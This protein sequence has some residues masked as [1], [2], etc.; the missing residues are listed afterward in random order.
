MRVRNNK[1]LDNNNC[2]LASGSL[3]L[4]QGFF[5]FF[6]SFLL[7]YLLLGGGAGARLLTD[8]PSVVKGTATKMTRATTTTTTRGLVLGGGLL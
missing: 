5:S 4:D 8:F 3:K 6:F 1:I 7:F 2:N